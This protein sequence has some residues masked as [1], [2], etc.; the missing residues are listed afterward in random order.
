MVTRLLTLAG[1]VLLL[2]ASPAEAAIFNVANTNDSGPGSLRQAVLSSNGNSEEDT[3]NVP[4][5]TY[6]LTS[7]Q[8]IVTDPLGVTI[9]G[10]GADSVLIASQ[11]NFRVFCITAGDEVLLQGVTIQGGRASPSGGC[12]DSQGGGIR[13]S[14][15][16]LRVTGSW[17]QHNSATPG[18]GGGGGIYSSGDLFVRD[19]I[20]R[21]NTA[22]ALSGVNNGGGGIYWAGSGFP[23]F[24]VSDSTVYENTATVAGNQSGGGGIWSNAQPNLANVTISGNVHR[25]N[26]LS[27][28][29]GGGIFV[30]T[31]NGG[32]S[33]VHATFS[34]NHSDRAG[35]AIAR[36][37]GTSPSLQDSVLNANTAQANPDCSTGAVVSGGGNVSSTAAPTCGLGGSD[38]AAVDPQLGPLAVNGAS[39]G[40]L[41]HELLSRESP[42]VEFGAN[43]PLPA[44]QRG[45]SRTKFFSFPP[46][47][48][49]S[50]AYEF[51][52]RTSADIPPC[53]PTGV[54]P[55]S[56]DAA[57]GGTVEGLSY[58]VGGGPPIVQDTGD[59]GAPVTP[60]TVTIPEGRTTLEYFG[61]WTNGEETGPGV[62]NVLVDKTRPTVDV[63]SQGGQ[64]IFV[65]T[66]RA[67]VNVSAADAL[68]GLV[69]D[70]SGRAVPINTRARGRRSFARTASDLC[71][72]QARDTF[73]YRVLAPGL[74]VRTVL[75][76]L[77]GAVRV[78]RGGGSAVASQKGQR[79]S[80]L[81]QPRELPVGSFIDTRRGTARLTTARTRREDQIQAGRFSAGVFQVLQSRRRRTR[82]LTELRLKG[83][84]FSRCR[85][86]G[87]GSARRAQSRIIRRLRGSARGRYRTRG[88]HSAATVRGTVWEVV[89]RC[90]GTLTRVIRGRVAVRDFRR[91]KTILVR[92]GK[93]YL[94]RPR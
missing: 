89:D 92:A 35:G 94:A 70:P 64:N 7:G 15:D 88:R 29:G 86:I 87:K 47:D 27:N 9:A 38:Q 41:T 59:S 80:A 13:S 62:D 49:D 22:T 30:L 46:P 71:N 58:S 4:A 28:G 56:L 1:A 6:N 84:N 66:R 57:P 16:I 78:R 63:A 23:S 31:G 85:R 24:E 43:C 37:A 2:F 8:L 12:N 52:G 51:D 39:N 5:G 54:I 11:G 10:A 65:I 74:G 40:T 76:R 26:G 60:T 72:N 45:V 69:Q 90:D 82:G 44:D 68:S 61:R 17:V 25:V 67:R 21:H 75:E 32:G 3:I 50:G 77:S 93:S 83:G 55:L 14:A 18:Q 42:A 34:G 19:S 91:R 79:F 33:I 73:N 81:T 36:D 48:C 53:S 20:V